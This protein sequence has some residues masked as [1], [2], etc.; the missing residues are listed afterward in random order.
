VKHR[1]VEVAERQ[2]AQIGLRPAA[3]TQIVR[4]RAGM[5]G[6]EL[7]VRRHPAGDVEI[8]PVAV[9]GVTGEVVGDELPPVLDGGTFTRGEVKR[10]RA[11][12]DVGL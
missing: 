10:G 12:R 2:L 5:D 4:H 3:A 8:G 1:G 6:A 11:V 9:L 7:Q